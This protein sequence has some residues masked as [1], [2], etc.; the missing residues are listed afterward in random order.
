MKEINNTTMKA[1]TLKISMK[2]F[3]ILL[4]FM[5][6]WNKPTGDSK[7]M[8]LDWNCL[9]PVVEKIEELD[10]VYKVE[11]SF[12]QFAIYSV[13]TFEDLGHGIELVFKVVVEFIKWH[14]LQPK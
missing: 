10:C 4:D 8:T 12:N 9:M 13:E 3:K 14:N 1:D 11:Y 7:V 5:P 2:E 6:E